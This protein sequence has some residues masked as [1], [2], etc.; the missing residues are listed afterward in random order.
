MNIEF[1]TT[2][3]GTLSC[4]AGGKRLH[5]A[6]NPIKEAQVFAQKAEC[7]FNPSFVI[8]TGP[9]LSY[10]AP[11]LKSRFSHSKV[12]AIHYSTA[13][14]DSDKEWDFV[15]YL[16]DNDL[17]LSQKLFNFMGE[18]GLSSC[19]FLSW[20]PSQQAFEKEYIQTWGQIKKSL[21]K[22]RD[23]LGTREYFSLR[24]AKNSVKFCSFITK[25]L[26]L[27]KKGNCPIII[28]ASGPSLK[29]SLPFLKKYRDSFF[30]LAL[31]SAYITLLNFG[32]EADLL[33]STDGGYWAKK[34]IEAESFYSRKQDIKLALSLEAACP[35]KI[36]KEASILPLSYGDGISESFIKTFFADSA[37]KAK[38]NGTVSG[39]AAYLALNLTTGPIFFCGL[40]LSTSKSFVH[41]A[42]NALEIAKESVDF[43]LG[44]KETRLTPSIFSSASLNIYRDWF[45][46]ETFAGRIMRLSDNYPYQNKLSLKDVDWDIFLQVTNSEKKV[47]Q[48]EKPIFQAKEFPKEDRKAKIIKIIEDNKGN[49]E[50]IKEASIAQAIAYQKNLGTLKEDEEKAKLKNKITR[51]CNKLGAIVKNDL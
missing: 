23:I 3:A 43:R 40:D 9:A 18:E 21:L 38:R 35:T 22:S 20:Q 2:P 4:T 1:F 5:S 37:F 31:S 26:S 49:L 7:D 30:L 33:L 39:T 19:L 41:T 45:K 16:S 8:V 46:T 11:F 24:W 25:T 12:G 50:W 6:Y 42:P 51:F 15:F 48:D 36:L 13:F 28:V 10:C 47:L 44:T 14:S 27:Q 29:G 32:L 34:H 17:E